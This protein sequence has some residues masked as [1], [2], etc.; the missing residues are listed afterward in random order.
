MN[1]GAHCLDRVVWLGGAQARTISATTLHRFG[2]AVETDATM[3]LQ[4]ANDVTAVVTVVSDS[5]RRK[6]EL[7]VVGERGSV[8]VNPQI[9]TVLRLDGQTVVLHESAAE[10]ISEAFLRQLADFAAA[11]AGQPS[12]VS[13]S[14]SRHVVELVLAAYDSAAGDGRTVH[15]DPRASRPAPVGSA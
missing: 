7:T 8:V 1:I 4:L 15:L 5:P 6:D 9:G 3:R 13:L 10:D 12:A 14:H 11:V 2:V